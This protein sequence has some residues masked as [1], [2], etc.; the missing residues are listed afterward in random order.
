[1]SF[2]CLQIFSIGTE[3]SYVTVTVH[4]SVG[5]VRVRLVG[6]YSA[7]TLFPKTL[8]TDGMSFS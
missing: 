3:S 5:M 2:L 6:A 4:L 1:M 7:F 8:S